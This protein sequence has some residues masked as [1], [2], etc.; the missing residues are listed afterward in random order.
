MSFNTLIGIINALIGIIRGQA[1][2]AQVKTIHFNVNSRHPTPSSLLH[3]IVDYERAKSS[4]HAKKTTTQAKI[5]HLM[6]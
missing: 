4:N 3:P 6:T 5:M 1:C 2:V